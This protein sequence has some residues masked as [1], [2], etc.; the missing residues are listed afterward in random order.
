MNVEVQHKDF[1][2]PAQ[3][4]RVQEKSLAVSYDDK[5]K[6]D[7]SVPYSQCRAVIT[8]APRKLQF[9]PGDQVEAFFKRSVEPTISAWQKGKVREIKVS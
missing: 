9:S 2:A 8:S 6:Q 4:V 7:E 1:F 5:W 3:V